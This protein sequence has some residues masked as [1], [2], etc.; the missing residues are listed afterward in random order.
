METVCIHKIF[1]HLSL[2]YSFL[3]VNSAI[4]I[5]I[6]G[7]CWG[8]SWDSR[9]KCKKHKH[10]TS[11]KW[12]TYSIKCLVSKY[13]STNRSYIIYNNTPLNHHILSFFSFSTTIKLDTTNYIVWKAQV[14]PAIRGNGLE[15]FVNR[16]KKAPTN[17]QVSIDGFQS[18]IAIESP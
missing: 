17:Y 14:L 12:N 8:W 4:S 10:W 5:L 18:A 7:I 1:F 13:C 6:Y 9:D 2:S 11:F 16:T 15:G 3:G